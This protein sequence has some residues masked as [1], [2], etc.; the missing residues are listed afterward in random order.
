MAFWNR[1][2]Q[3]TAGSVATWRTPDGEYYNISNAALTAEHSLIAGATGCGKSTFLHSII[4]AALVQHSP[5]A[6]RFILIDPKAVELARYK[7]L[8]HTLEY[9]DTE[10]GAL[11]ALEY[12][13][14]IMNARYKELVRSGRENWTEQ[15][16]AAV[17]VIIEE[18][19]DLMTCPLKR[20]IQVAIQRLTQKGRAAGIHI[21]AATQAPSRA[22]IPAA[23]QLN[24][25]A[26]FALACETA[27]ESKQ[28]IG[29]AGAEALPDHGEVI[30]K[31]R[32][33]I[34]RYTVP[35]MKKSEVMELVNYWTSNACRIA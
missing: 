24:F 6:V 26:R 11:S 15:D 27:I 35:F 16:G 4:A 9:T 28:I 13:Q 33:N 1:N 14:G 23:L 2:K 18:L 34:G 12:A 30:Y 17:Y 3:K 19:A 21:I 5:A 32:R 8:P 10:D 25:T 31:Y 7:N 20:E 29:I 22:V